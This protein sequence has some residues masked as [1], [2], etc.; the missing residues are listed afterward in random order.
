MGIIIIPYGSKILRSLLRRASILIS[1]D[2]ALN[3]VIFCDECGE[4]YVLETNDMKEN[5]IMFECEICHT[6][7]KVSVPGYEAKNKPYGGRPKG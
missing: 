5:V 6:L 4:R 1:T 2:G 3:M 7:V